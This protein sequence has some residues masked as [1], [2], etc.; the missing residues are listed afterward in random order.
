MRSALGQYIHF[1]ASSYVDKGTHR[2]GN[3][4]N[5]ERDIFQRHRE[6]ILNQAQSLKHANLRMLEDKYNTANYHLFNRLKSMFNRASTLSE[7]VDI[8]GPI[9]RQI[10]Q[11]W[12]D[13]EIAEFVEHLYFNEKTQT[14]QYIGQKGTLRAS[15]RINISAVPTLVGE[16][17]YRYINT[18]Y[19][20]CNELIG[21]IKASDLDDVSKNNFIDK[22]KSIAADALDLI[23]NIEMKTSALASLGSSSL[24]RIPGRIP[25]QAAD[26]LLEELQRI[27][28]E[29]SSIVS[30]NQQLQ[31]GFSE[32]MG[33][34]IANGAA[35]VA[36]AALHDVFR[37]VART[38][39][40]QTVALK[41]A[42]S[43]IFMEMDQSILE[44]EFIKGQAADRTQIITKSKEGDQVTYSFSAIHDKVNQKTDIAITIQDTPLNI[45]MKNTD[46]SKAFINEANRIQSPGIELQNSSLFLYLMGL[47]QSA[48]ENLGTHYLNI[49]SD[50]PP[51]EN[52]DEGTIQKMRKDAV[53]S[54]S[55]AIL[56]SSLTGQGQ[57]RSGG[58]ANILA[59]QDKAKKLSNG[60]PRTR[61]FD[62]S[63]IINSIDKNLDNF[64]TS[65]NIENLIFSNSW[66]G[67]APSRT[68]ANKRI[69]KVLIEARQKRITAKLS[70]QFLNNLSRT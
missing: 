23:K 35:K 57:M 25:A 69:T 45:S 13:L 28:S 33:N 50:H 27:G 62:M 22:I 64:I 36:D 2:W 70:N 52:D 44:E 68:S 39:T 37:K 26:K 46:L 4:G 40:Q 51:G 55:L 20:R 42:D 58:E 15:K 14:L 47:Q 61:F 16:D 53:H 17:S 32:F 3:S 41:G 8:M 12:S 67:K 18:V 30:L 63:D 11:S 56:Y 19:N 9:L 65:P 49:F 34:A 54:L 24:A 21:K 59:V 29:A 43:R 1:F 5:F 48:I 66:E 6:I 38:G 7:K 60:M 10:N 31:A